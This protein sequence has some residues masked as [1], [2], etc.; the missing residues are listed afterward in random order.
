MRSTGS[1][2]VLEY[3]RCL[4]VERLAE[5]YST[6]EVADFLGV[7]PRSVRRWQSAF[8]RHAGEGLAARG[9]AGRPPQLTTTQEKIVLRW[10]S[11]SP[12]EYGFATDLWSA[13]RLA[14]LIAQEFD[15]HFHPN[16]LSTW[17]RQRGYTPQKP[18]RVARERDDE[19]IARWLAQDWPRIKQKARRRRACLLLL[20]ESGLLMAPLV[21][22]SWALR[23]H[24]PHQEQKVRHREKVSVAAALWLSPQRDRLQ[25]AYQ[26]LVNDYF[27]NVEVADFL[28]GA[29]QG[30]S[31][32][33]LVLWDEGTMHKGSPLRELVAESAGRLTFEA[34][35][36]YAPELMP[37]EFLWRWLKYG[38]LCNFAPTDAR[39]LN[40]AVVREL[41]AVRDN[42]VLLAS[43]VHQSELPW[44]RT[45]IT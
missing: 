31:D 38:R 32:P 45:L 23:G 16:Y 37:V 40:E 24:P 19:A 26:T 35:P 30:L 41:E 17:L 1:P 34:M 6:Q 33:I 42:Q 18:R 28:S 4:A 43:F 25:L 36:A 13:P 39:H 22:R 5:G 10:L 14:Q 27:T 8:R 7:D 15:A 21:R 29:V 3:R 12:T 2:D 9:G 20:D 11:D 44:W